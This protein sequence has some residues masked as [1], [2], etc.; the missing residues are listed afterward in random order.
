MTENTPRSVSMTSLTALRLIDALN[1]LRDDIAVQH[2]MIESVDI[3]M[4][5]LYAEMRAHL[6]ARSP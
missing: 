5:A 2:A 3:A 1:Q 4:T 6:K